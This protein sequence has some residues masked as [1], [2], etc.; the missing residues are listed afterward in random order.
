MAKSSVESGMNLLYAAASPV[1]DRQ[2]GFLCPYSGSPVAIKGTTA[3]HKILYETS[4]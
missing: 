2:W 3:T 1:S 4:E